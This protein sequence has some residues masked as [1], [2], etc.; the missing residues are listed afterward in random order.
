MQNR[1]RTVAS[2]QVRM[3]SSRLPGKVMRVVQ[4]RPLLGFLVGRLRLCQTLDE[5]IVATSSGIENDVIES[6]CDSESVEDALVWLLILSRV[7]S[8][9]VWL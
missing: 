1:D 5:I 8:P 6:F 3:G 2:I 9:V 7:I 4:N